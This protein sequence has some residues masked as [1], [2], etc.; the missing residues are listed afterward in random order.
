MSPPPKTST[1]PTSHATGLAAGF[2]SGIEAGL[3]VIMTVIMAVGLA[4]ASAGPAAAQAVPRP[5]PKGL[6]FYAKYGS[7]DDTAAVRNPYILGALFQIYWSDV[8]KSRGTFDWSILDAWMDPWKR[9]G[10]KVALRILWSTSGYW[11]DPSAKRPTPAWVWADGAVKLTHEPSGTEIPLFWDPIYLKHARAF[12]AEVARRYDADPALLFL[13]MTPGAETNPYRFGTINDRDTSFPA[14]FLAAKASDGRAYEA[15]LWVATVKSFVD[16]AAAGF[17]R[18][19]LLVTLNTGGMPGAGSR[20]KEIGDH[21]VT[22][23]TW[24]GQNGLTGS[25]Y[26][27]PSPART[28]FLDWSGRSRVFFETLHA[29]AED[30]ERM[31]TLLEVMQAAQRAGFSYLNVYPSDVLKGT[32][33]HSSHDPAYEDALRHG[34]E[35]LQGTV[36]LAPPGPRAA[37]WRTYGQAGIPRIVQALD[38]CRSMD[39]L[40]RLLFRKGPP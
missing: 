29:T 36:R 7:Q 8:E 38:G 35:A 24:V 33:G 17:I 9:A 27:S 37:P 32:P 26:S 21:C 5:S 13:D 1:P 4:L 30:P 25:S 16:S 39:A 14:R 10:K 19:P 11:P 15:D 12:L 18:T 40:G 34:H 6:L 2:A 28:N 22:A 3:A 31:G 23:G 20:Q